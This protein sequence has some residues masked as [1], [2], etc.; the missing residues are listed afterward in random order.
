VTSTHSDD[1]WLSEIQDVEPLQ[2]TNVEQLKSAARK[3]LKLKSKLDAI[4]DRYE[5]QVTL[6]KDLHGFTVDQAHKQTIQFIEHSF[7]IGT[8]E[9]V[10]ITG[11]SGQIKQEMP[12]WLD[13]ISHVQKYEIVNGGSYKVR[14][15]KRV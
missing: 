6:Q 3:P 8:R 15:K 13:L 1:P 9:V 2:Q 14:I 5:N 11:A 7:A 12:R 4:R 10:L